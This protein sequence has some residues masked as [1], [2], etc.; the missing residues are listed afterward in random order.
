MKPQSSSARS[1]FSFSSIANRLRNENPGES[2]R[3][4][5]KRL[6]S[7]EKKKELVSLT[8]KLTEMEVEKATGFPLGP[9]S[10]L[11]ESPEEELIQRQII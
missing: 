9:H 8:Q 7:L 6:A 3:K 10:I 1:E 11:S 2:L 5:K 4:I